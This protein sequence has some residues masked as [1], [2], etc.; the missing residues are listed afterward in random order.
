MVGKR[1]RGVRIGL[2]IVSG[3]FSFWESRVLF[4]LVFSLSILLRLYLINLREFPAGDEIWAYL[5]TKADI[6][7]IWFGTLSDFHAPFYFM[8]LRF[9]KLAF[10][11]ELNIFF[12]R[13]ISLIFGIAASFAVWVLASKVFD[14]KAGLI[15]FYMSLFL[16]G[17][18]W[19]SIYGRYYSFLILLTTISLIFFLDFLKKGKV[20]YLIY[21]TVLSVL[22]AFT[23]YYFLLIDFSFLKEDIDIF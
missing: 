2:G 23:H 3:K 21:L 6:K 9:I 22:G 5:L 7:S 17:Y 16:P 19:A 4:L 11:F 1:R 10:P 14:K 20:K 18:I 15:V 13:I 12:I 8:F